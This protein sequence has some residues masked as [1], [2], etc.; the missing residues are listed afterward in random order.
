MKIKYLFIVLFFSIFAKSQNLDFENKNYILI[1]EDYQFDTN[2]RKI[3]INIEDKY[4]LILYP[5]KIKN[6]KKCKTKISN[7]YILSI[8]ELYK[9]DEKNIELYLKSIKNKRLFLIM[10]FNDKKY[11][12]QEYNY[13][14]D[15][16]SYE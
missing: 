7:D 6:K 9:L 2:H 11:I 14:F 3:K 15:Q 1:E 12:L 13:I 5:V 8:K 10:N 4:Y 16:I